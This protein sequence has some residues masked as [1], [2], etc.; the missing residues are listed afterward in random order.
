MAE[1]YLVITFCLFN[2]MKWEI[3]VFRDHLAGDQTATGKY[4]CKHIEC[5]IIPSSL[6]K[7]RA[8][9]WPKTHTHTYHTLEVA[10]E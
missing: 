5:T 7:K 6:V 3:C 4:Y 1:C 2:F 8:E 10:C 9:H